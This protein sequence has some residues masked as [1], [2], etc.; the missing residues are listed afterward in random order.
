V[1]KGTASFAK[2]SHRSFLGKPGGFYGLFCDCDLDWK[3]SGD[4]WGTWQGRQGLV[5]TIYNDFTENWHVL[6]IDLNQLAP[7]D[8]YLH[9]HYVFLSAEYA[10]DAGFAINDTQVIV[11]GLEKLQSMFGI[12]APEIVYIRPDGFIGLRSQDLDPGRLR[13]YLG[14][15]YGIIESD[16]IATT[17]TEPS[18]SGGNQENEPQAKLL[19]GSKNDSGLD[20]ETETSTPVGAE[21]FLDIPFYRTH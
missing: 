18:I 7:L 2:R 21:F 14:R 20:L 13:N 15:I 11:D 3:R 16:A 8:R 1:R 6:I 12:R 10:K 17:S 4:I 19:Q 9:V 5:A